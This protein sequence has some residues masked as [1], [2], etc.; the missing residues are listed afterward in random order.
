MTTAL[1]IHG[2]WQGAWAWDAFLPHFSARG[3]ACR[4]VDLPENGRPGAGAG[5]ACLEAY[6][7]HCAEVLGEAGVVIAHSGGGVVASQLAEAFPERVSC[8]V[9]LAGMML[10]SG[11]GFADVLN[12]LAA[13]GRVSPG[14]GP[15]LRWS[16]DG[17]FSRVPPE[18]AFDIF[19]HDCPPEA[20]R[21]AADSLGPQRESGRAMRATLTPDRFGRVPRLYVEALNDRSVV[22]EVQRRMQALSPGARR[23]SIETGHVPQLA[24]PERL[25]ALL[26]DALAAY[27]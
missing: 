4:A 26:D 1:L 25:A 10:P 5:P 2:A 7:A 8:V 14:I 11:V 27:R 19:L 16:D 15:Y 18:A 24:Q 3:W 6:V 21:R 13:E 20:A 12:D 23:L 17:R 9:Y 22:L